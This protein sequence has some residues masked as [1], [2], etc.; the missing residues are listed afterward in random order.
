MKR[1]LVILPI[2][3][4]ETYEPGTAITVKNGYTD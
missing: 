3:G 1:R 4:S 2:Y